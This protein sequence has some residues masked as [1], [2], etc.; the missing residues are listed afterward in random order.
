MVLEVEAHFRPL[1]LDSPLR[2]WRLQRWF[3]ENE[4]FGVHDVVVGVKM[5]GEP[6]ESTKTRSTSS[7]QEY[8]FS[9]DIQRGEKEWIS[10][11]D[12]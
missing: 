1:F 7:G 6:V 11:A 2:N 5:V 4:Q 8:W 3:R 10:D 9:E 12:I